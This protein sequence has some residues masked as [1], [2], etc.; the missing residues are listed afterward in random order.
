[1]RNQHLCLNAVIKV[2]N[3]M[4]KS[5]I[6]TDDDRLLRILEN[7]LI[8]KHDSIWPHGLNFRLHIDSLLEVSEFRRSCLRYNWPPTEAECSQDGATINIDRVRKHLNASQEETT[9]LF[10]K[11]VSCASA[12]KPLTTSHNSP[13]KQL[14]KSTLQPRPEWKNPLEN[15]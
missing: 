1:M 2:Y 10:D 5:Y 6:F 3:F 4:C 8:L 14:R 12:S 13:M 15:R 9:F 11:A 7:D